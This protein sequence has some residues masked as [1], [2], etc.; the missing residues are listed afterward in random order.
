MSNRNA[1]ADLGDFLSKTVVK[2]ETNRPVRGHSLLSV[3]NNVEEV[4]GAATGI[5]DSG[6]EFDGALESWDSP[7]AR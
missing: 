6:K 2:D 4:G 5:V 7:R 3:A 1:S